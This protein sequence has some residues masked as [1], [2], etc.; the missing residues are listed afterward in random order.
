[1]SRK[2]SS[3]EKQDLYSRHLSP[4][5]RAIALY[6]AYRDGQITAVE[7]EQEAALIPQPATEVH[8]LIAIAN[9]LNAIRKEK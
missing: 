1:M 6:Q 4:T 7:Y 2:K 8:A 3:P 5:R 9:T